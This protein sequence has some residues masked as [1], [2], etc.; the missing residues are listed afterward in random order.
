MS[1]SSKRDSS[2]VAKSGLDKTPVVDGVI[3]PGE[4]EPPQG[5]VKK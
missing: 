2:A 3:T 4:G 1:K 5:E